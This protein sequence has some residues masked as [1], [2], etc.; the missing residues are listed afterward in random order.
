MIMEDKDY[1]ARFI[2]GEC[3]PQ[4]QELVLKEAA[5]NP[6][7]KQH[8]Y[9]LKNL[10]VHENMP[11]CHATDQEYSDFKKYA[12]QRM[13]LEESENRNEIEQIHIASEQKN[14]RRTVMGIINWS[15]VAAIIVLLA[16]NL[17][18]NFINSEQRAGASEVA[19]TQPVVPDVAEA[20]AE[21]SVEQLPLEPIN[22]L[23][24][25]KGVKGETVLPDGSKVTLN[26]DSRITY[27]ARFSG[28]TREVE[29]SGEGYF[30]VQKDSLHPMV[31]RCNKNF[32]VIVYGTTFNI[33]SY[34]N[35]NT[36]KTTL[37]SGSIKIVENVDGK[38]LVR[39][40]VPNQ[41]YTIVENKKLATLET[42]VDTEKVCEWKD[43]ILS[44]DSTPLSEVAKI[45]ERWHGIKIVI[46]NSSKLNIPITARFTTESIVQ[47]M[48]LLKFSTDIR[49]SVGDNIVYIR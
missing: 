36:A 25:A 45:L 4:E 13:L 44:F 34:G 49:Y 21:S 29:F 40:I 20:V 33:K 46:E 9:E 6:E 28:N 43:G 31:V 10:Y 26:S 15:A 19:L 27:P 5:K 18:F 39:D 48:D 3:T 17:K 23:Y 42:K 38:E 41:S 47:I 22:V 14:R 12:M 7:F 8:L 30:E 35:D 24:T 11:D 1:I 37:I 16:L 32:K 2:Q